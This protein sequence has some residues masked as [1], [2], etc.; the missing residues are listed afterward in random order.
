M[1][2]IGSGHEARVFRTGPTT[3]VKS[4]KAAPAASTA[5]RCEMAALRRLHAVG[6]AVPR[7]IA[8]DLKPLSLTITM[9]WVAGSICDDIVLN[10]D[11]A[12]ARTLGKL[13]AE[14]HV[15]LHQARGDDDYAALIAEGVPLAGTA[16]GA[17]V[18]SETRPALTA[19]ADAGRA[20]LCHGDFHPA[21]VIRDVSM[22]VIDWTRAFIGPAEADVATSIMVPRLLP[23]GVDWSDAEW[24]RVDA[25]IVAYEEAY[26]SRY[27]ALQPL[28][29]PTVTA[30]LPHVARRFGVQPP[31]VPPRW[32]QE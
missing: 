1:I 4:F 16:F 17:G 2:E 5:A 22:T 25:N 23:R 11:T 7:P 9:A 3:V 13:L 15:Q 29:R 8:I 19:L 6:Y 12:A 24:A 27:D 30:W 20:V 14:L 26:L 32:Q 21:N 10:E 28:D 31:G 18:S